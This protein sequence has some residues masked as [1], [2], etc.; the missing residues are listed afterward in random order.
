MYIMKIWLKVQTQGVWRLNRAALQRW[1]VFVPSNRVWL[2][3]F[4]K[5]ATFPLDV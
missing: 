5:V 4:L 2:Q 3:L 1:V